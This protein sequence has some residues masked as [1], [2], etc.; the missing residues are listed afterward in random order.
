MFQSNEDFVKIQ[1]NDL[2]LQTTYE[3]FQKLEPNNIL[4]NYRYISFNNDIKLISYVVKDNSQLGIPDDIKLEILKYCDKIDLYSQILNTIPEVPLSV[5]KAQTLAMAES[6]YRNNPDTWKVVLIPKGQPDF[7]KNDWDIN[8]VQLKAN[9]FLTSGLQSVSL[10]FWNK[11]PKSKIPQT[12]ITINTE[13]LKKLQQRNIQLE[14][15]IGI[16]YYTKLKTEIESATIETIKSY[17]VDFIQSKFADNT[18]I[19]R[20][21]EVE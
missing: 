14:Q 12:M 10:S 21:I 2:I 20:I 8:T 13:S 9:T 16:F 7:I 11:N 6:I 15:S 3:E 18:L 17:T 1:V 19:N 4:S 5:L